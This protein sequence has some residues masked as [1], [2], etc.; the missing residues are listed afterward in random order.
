M[1]SIPRHTFA[2]L[3]A[4]LLAP[5]AVLDGADGS[6]Q[7]PAE[8]VFPVKAPLSGERHGSL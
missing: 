7:T 4:L 5:L 2:A 1:N 6:P 8:V 3:T